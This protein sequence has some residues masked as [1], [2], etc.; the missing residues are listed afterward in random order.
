M[1]SIIE[2]VPRACNLRVSIASCPCGHL[3]MKLPTHT[4]VD[5]NALQA[6]LQQAFPQYE[7]GPRQSFLVVAKSGWVGANV[8]VRK[9]KVLVVGNFG[10]MGLQIAFVLAVV[11]L[12]FLIPLVLYLV[13]VFGKQRAVEKE[14]GA[15]V[16][17]FI[18]G[19]A[20]PQQ[21]APGYAPA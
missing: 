13:F 15:V 8:V 19:A 9:N 17:A 20:Q 2:G 16:Q 6:Y 7:V 10:S 11:L 1:R 21:M 12:G 3:A 5:K 4:Q 18:A 14:V